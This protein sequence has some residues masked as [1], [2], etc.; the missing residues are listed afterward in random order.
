VR[1]F[2]SQRSELVAKLVGKRSATKAP[3]KVKVPAAAKSPAAVKGPAAGKAPAAAKT[4][5]DV[6]TNAAAKEMG[7][8]AP[9]VQYVPPAAIFKKLIRR[10]KGTGSKDIVSMSTQTF[11]KLLEMALAGSFD[12]KAYMDKFADIRIGVKKGTIP[13]P[14]RHFVT[15]GYFE[16]RVP[17]KYDV[18]EEWYLKTYPDVAQAI[19][20][21]M[22]R[23]G[24]HHFE[25]FGFAEGRVPNKD[26]QKT[27]GEWHDLQ[28]YY[29]M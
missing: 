4:S 19:K 16:G 10:Q 6:K 20:S 25:A 2:S 18:D 17:L 8:P 3:A 7:T 12:E 11:Y 29:S 27:V 23:N 24:A 15:D 28:R 26:F 5:T 9:Y 21:G 14:L 22:V 1:N 13:S